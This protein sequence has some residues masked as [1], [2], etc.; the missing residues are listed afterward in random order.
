VTRRPSTRLVALAVAL[1]LVCLCAAA[2]AAPI[3]WHDLFAQTTGGSFGGSS[4]GSGAS[5][6]SSSSSSSGGGGGLAEALFSLLFEIILSLLWEAFLWCLTEHTAPTL[7]VLATIALFAWGL[8]APVESVRNTRPDP[9][10]P[11]RAAEL[12][13]D[14]NALLRD[15]GRTTDLVS[16]AGYALSGALSL[17]GVL[18]LA[19]HGGHTANLFIGLGALAVS[20]ALGVASW[21]AR[22]ARAPL[23]HIVETT[24]SDLDHLASAARRFDEL[25][26]WVGG[27]LVCVMV[28][29]AVLVLVGVSF[30]P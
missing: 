28:T 2:Y 10:A 23:A 18:T 9:S 6:S 24:G 11:R 29:L 15:L 3:A 16:F 27:V 21:R 8:R 1:A 4:W 30:A 25:F 7:A 12:G 19:R 17:A 26:A 14:D 13:A 5:S 22:H 20:V